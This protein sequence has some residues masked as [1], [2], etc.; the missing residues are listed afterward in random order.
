MNEATAWIAQL[1][2]R[3]F[4]LPVLLHLARRDL[5]RGR[6]AQAKARFLHC[7]QLVP[8]SFQAHFG[9]ACIYLRERDYSRAQRELMLAKEIAPSRYRSYKARLPELVGLTD[10]APSASAPQ[11]AASE[12]AAPAAVHDDW[13]PESAPPFPGDFTDHDEWLKFR[14]MGPIS[15]AD[16]IGVDWDEVVARILRDTP[17]RCA[18]GRT[19]TQAPTRSRTWRRPW[20]RRCAATHPACAPCSG[21]PPGPA[22]PATGC[23]RRCCC[24][25]RSRACRAHSTR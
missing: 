6:V 4:V 17:G 16:A 9:L 13:P 25:C 23:A 15:S 22:S 21:G 7:T 12:P 10:T 14:R 5:K 3:T 8:F 18:P 11:P 24:W 2:R 1:W 19:G 20:R